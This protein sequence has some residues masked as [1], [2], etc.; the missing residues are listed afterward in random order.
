MEAGKVLAS[1]SITQQ[2]TEQQLPFK[3]DDNLSTEAITPRVMR[4]SFGRLG[5]A[6]QYSSEVI[7]CELAA[8]QATEPSVDNGRVLAES[9]AIS[10]FSSQQNQSA[11]G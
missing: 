7:N 1:Q 6:H 3:K 8:S 2:I 5:E 9:D 10:S 11:V 4:E